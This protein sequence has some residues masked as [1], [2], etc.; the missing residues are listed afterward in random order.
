Q[1]TAEGNKRVLEGAFERVALP[2]S[3]SFG[4]THNKHSLLYTH[5]AW[6][7]DDGAIERPVEDLERE[8]L[9]AQCIKEPLFGEPGRQ[10]TAF[11]AAGT[12]NTLARSGEVDAA[13][14]RPQPQAASNSAAASSAMKGAAA[15]VWGG[16]EGRVSSSSAMS[17]PLAGASAGPASPSS[18]GLVHWM[19]VMADHDVHYMWNGVEGR[20]PSNIEAP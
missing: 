13:P 11:A 6:Q 12:R 8:D 9:L 14:W 17:G 19:S 4:S 2:F 15:L 10:R 7:Y 18:A 1:S 16:S 5:K 20:Q 3:P